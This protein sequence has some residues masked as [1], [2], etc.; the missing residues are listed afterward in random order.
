M[1]AP[2]TRSGADLPL[3]EELRQ[4]LRDITLG[5]S[6]DRDGEA[7][8]LHLEAMRWPQLEPSPELAQRLA[9]IPAAPGPAGEPGREPRRR[10][11]H[12][13]VAAELL[14]GRGAAAAASWFL[15]AAMTLAVDDPV[16]L[17]LRASSEVR[18][19]TGRHL[20]EPAARAGSSIQADLSRRF[21]ALQASV[22]APELPGLPLTRGAD[23]VRNWFADAIESSTAAVRGLPDLLPLPIPRA[24][25]ER[26]GANQVVPRPG[27]GTSIRERTFT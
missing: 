11:P 15:A 2:L 4:A 7:R 21:D 13:T 27:A 18:N 20:L 23:E 19:A 1:K 17:G 9:A 10:R 24:D 25:G 16:G 5:P 22:Q 3:P 8:T 12:R 6:P 14:R 26:P